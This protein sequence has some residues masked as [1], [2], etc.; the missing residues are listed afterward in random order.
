MVS[1]GLAEF[2]NAQGRPTIPPSNKGITLKIEENEILSLCKGSQCAIQAQK[3][4]DNQQKEAITQ[5]S[6]LRAQQEQARAHEQAH[7]RG[8][9]R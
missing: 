1:E 5:S 2:L 6:A 4:K 3:A 7:Q 9:E 8:R